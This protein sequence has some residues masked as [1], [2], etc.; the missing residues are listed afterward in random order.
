LRPGLF[1]DLHQPKPFFDAGDVQLALRD[2]ESV[3]AAPAREVPGMVG[4]WSADDLPGLPPVPVPPG[5]R[6]AFTG[7]DRYA[8]AREVIRFA[9]EPLAVVAAER[10]AAAEDGAERVGLELERLEPLT[11][12]AQATAPGA[13]ELFGGRSNIVSEREFGEPAGDV[14]ARAPVVVEAAYREQL[15]IPTSLEARA[16]LARAD[17]DGGLTVWVSH[18][19]QHMLRTAL[20]AAFDTDAERVRVVVPAVGGAFGAKSGTYP[21]YVLAAHLA[22]LLG[23]PVRWVEDRAEALSTATRGRGQDQWV[24]LAATP[25]G[26]L[27]GYEL[28]IDA[29][30]GAYPHTGDMIPAMTGVMSA[31]CYATPRVHARVRTVLTTTPPT[32]AY[33]GA[34]RP[35]AAYAIE[36]TMD[37]LARR[38]G[39]DPAELRRRNFIREFPYA[40]P[41]GRTYDSGNYETALDKALDA[42]GYAELR[43]EQRRRRR[44]GGPPLS[45]GIASYVERSAGPLRRRDPGG[46]HPARLPAAGRR[47][48]APGRTARN[49]DGE[50]QRAV[51]QQGSG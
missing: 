50:P 31:G 25:D 14:F 49:R 32:S 11:S 34:G 15:V 10:R 46:G 22:Q 2:C 13:P 9:G 33:R 23:R 39:M 40:T 47:R 29:P 19:A 37:L 17:G 45:I 35:E 41:S 7:L 3:D 16:V 24:R 8:L 4:A 6:E 1:S 43:R 51:R 36:R 21:E 48:H 38:L 30:V 26:K 12:A 28:L 18:Q 5:S 20:A 44:R 42:V 27:L